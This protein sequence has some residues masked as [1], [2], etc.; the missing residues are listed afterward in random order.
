M[1]LD[2]PLRERMGGVVFGDGLLSPVRWDEPANPGRKRERVGRGVGH[3]SK[4][5]CVMLHAL[6]GKGG[7]VS[8]TRRAR[9]V[10]P[11]RYGNGS[12][13]GNAP[14]LALP[15]VPPGRNYPKPAKAGGPS[16]GQH[17]A[18]VVTDPR[19]AVAGG[20]GGRR[21]PQIRGERREARRL[22]ATPLGRTNGPKSLALVRDRTPEVK[23]RRVGP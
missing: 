3:R 12:W 21:S 9:R 1:R 17:P 22:R 11:G 19:E 10:A 16:I 8:R 20:K 6:S 4:C 2:E 23:L 13:A 14:R 15:R 7:P 5:R 18:H